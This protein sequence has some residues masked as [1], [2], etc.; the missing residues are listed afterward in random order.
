METQSIAL[1]E[2]QQ[3]DVW[4]G[5]LSSEILARYFGDLAGRFQRRQRRLT[6]LTLVFSSAAFASIVGSDWLP[7]YWA[8]LKPL[9]ALIAAIASA[10]LVVE[11]YDQRA[12]E[13]SDLYSG[14]SL[15]A[16]QF[17]EL[18]DDM[19]SNDAPARLRALEEKSRELSR[20]GTKMPEK[21]RLLLRWQ[22]YIEKRHNLPR[23]A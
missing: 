15:L 2:L 13:C 11:R 19:Y 3:T 16:N 23:A 5:W 6:L 20:I 14:W 9:C 8:W 18:W 17:Q 12:V 7:P 4:E 1:S 10:V 21:K 22:D